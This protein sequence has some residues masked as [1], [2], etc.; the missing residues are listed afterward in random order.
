MATKLEA[1]E[2]DPR[3]RL[4]ALVSVLSYE[5]WVSSC[6]TVRFNVVGAGSPSF[7]SGPGGN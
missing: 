4:F 1:E 5:V 7:R 6:L 2:T 3:D